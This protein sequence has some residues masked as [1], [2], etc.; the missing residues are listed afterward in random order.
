MNQAGSA[1]LAQDFDSRRSLCRVVVRDAGV[2]RLAAAHC[3][4]QRA[5]GFFNGRIGI[6][7]MGVEDIDVLQAHAPEALI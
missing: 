2:E 3:L 1:Q 4:V 7:A 6:G 5:H